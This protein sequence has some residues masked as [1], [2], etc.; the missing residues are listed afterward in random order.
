MK[1]ESEKN[2]DVFRELQI[3]N[4][5]VFFEINFSCIK[6]SLILMIKIK[7]QEFNSTNKIKLEI[8][9]PNPKIK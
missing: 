9:S 5:E 6:N 4:K 3:I 2:I 7:K 1:I 8:L